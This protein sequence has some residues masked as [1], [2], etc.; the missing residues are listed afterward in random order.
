[1]GI[2]AAGHRAARRSGATG[3]SGPHYGAAGVLPGPAGI[4][5]ATLGVVKTEAKAQLESR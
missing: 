1:M 3:E 4:V 5:R 2:E